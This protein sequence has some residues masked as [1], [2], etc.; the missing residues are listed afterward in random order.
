MLVVCVLA[1]TPGMSG[2]WHASWMHD[3]LQQ[4]LQ[5]RLARLQGELSARRSVEMLLECGQSQLCVLCPSSHRAVLSPIDVFILSALAKLGATVAT[6][7]MQL[8]KS[9]LQ[10]GVTLLST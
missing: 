4:W 6:Y 2:W 3:K 1:C 10:V 7:P 8:I 9:R 5:A